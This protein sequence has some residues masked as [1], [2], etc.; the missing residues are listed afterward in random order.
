MAARGKPKL[1]QDAPPERVWT[2]QDYIDAYHHECARVVNK[3]KEMME[4]RESALKEIAAKA[5]AHVGG[6]GEV[7]RWGYGLQE[8]LMAQYAHKALG[9]LA[10]GHRDVEGILA[11]QLDE[12]E[13]QFRH[14]S[15]RIGSSSAFMNAVTGEAANVAAS[16]ADTVCRRYLE[17]IREYRAMAEEL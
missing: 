11:F 9:A 16:Y 1:R 6:I 2:K 10:A 3:W 12:I 8:D 4:E 7:F 14:N 13:N 17:A 5:A 15:F